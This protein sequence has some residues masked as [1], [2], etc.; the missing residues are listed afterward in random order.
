M[1]VENSSRKST[2]VFDEKHFRHLHAPAKTAAEVLHFAIGFRREIKELHDFVGAAFARRRGEPVK[3]RVGEQI[4]A[5]GEKHF[6]GGFLQHHRNPAADLERLRNHV[7]SFDP[8]AA[9]GGL[10][11]RRENFQQRR[12]SRAVRAKQAKN[13]PARNVEAQTVD[14]PHRLAARAEQ[15]VAA[16][17]DKP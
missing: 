15:S 16:A 17:A 13:R 10:Q 8:R 6:D 11:E 7:K 9:A 1:P 5:H 4:V 3:T 12:F 2:G 14:R